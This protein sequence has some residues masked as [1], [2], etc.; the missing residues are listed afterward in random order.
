MVKD[1]GHLHG[2]P[3]EV[4][5]GLTRGCS[6]KKDLIQGS[7]VQVRAFDSEPSTSAVLGRCLGLGS[8]MEHGGKSGF[9]EI[10]KS[11]A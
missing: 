8:G 10:L 11:L 7:E 5:A 9:R 1:G 3:L 2:G 4:K 6:R